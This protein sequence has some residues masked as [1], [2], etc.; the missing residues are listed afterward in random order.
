MASKAVVAWDKNGPCVGARVTINNNVLAGLTNGDGYLLDEANQY[1]SGPAV[2]EVFANGHYMY[3]QQCTL[4]G[5]N[6]NICCGSP[7]SGNDV[8]LPALTFKSSSNFRAMNP[9]WK[10]NDCGIHLSYLPPI[11]GG[12]SDATLFVAWLYDRYPKDIRDRIRVDYAR[13]FTHIA[14]SWPDAA[15]W[16]HTPSEFLS[17]CQEWDDTTVDV[18]VFLTA[19][20]NGYDHNV[21]DAFM[22]AA[23]FLD[24]AA[25]IIPC[26]IAGWELSLWLDTQE[27]WQLAALVAD[28]VFKVNIQTLLYIHLQEGYMSFPKPGEDNASFWWPLQGT[29]HGILLQKNLGWDDGQFANWLQDVLQRLDGLWNMP[30][31]NGINGE[32]NQGV[33]WELN[34]MN[35]FFDGA[36]TSSGNHLGDIAI[37]QT[38]NDIKVM[39]SGNGE[40]ALE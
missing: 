23:E 37:A 3:I 6:Q 9:Y 19:K 18:G 39:G 36:P 4:D 16:G 25:G 40:D 2:V 8:S 14:L 29:V 15:A 38:F 5:N 20:G 30:P 32:H 26:F 12:S 13:L 27:I 33:G 11:E 21:S 28:L 34:Y 7:V 10:G 31:T 1:P 17:I 22:F 35:Q 24:V